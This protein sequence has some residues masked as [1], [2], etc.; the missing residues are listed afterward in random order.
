MAIN[1]I[2][3]AKRKKFLICLEIK[4]GEETSGRKKC[5]KIPHNLLRSYEAISLDFSLC[6]EFTSPAAASIHSSAAGRHHQVSQTP[7][8]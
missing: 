8:W 4:D 6:R 1:V 3:K 5:M 2:F 7:T